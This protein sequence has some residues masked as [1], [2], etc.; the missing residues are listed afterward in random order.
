MALARCAFPAAFEDS[1]SLQTAKQGEKLHL[2]GL[3]TSPEDGVRVLLDEF[4]LFDVEVKNSKQTPGEAELVIAEGAVDVRHGVAVLK[5][6]K[7]T[8]W[9]PGV[10][11]RENHEPDVQSGHLHDRMCSQV[12]CRS[13]LNQDGN[14]RRVP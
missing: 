9:H 6:A 2:A 11:K 4:G 14:C 1:L 10:H 3:V 12:I 13:L 8:G 7:V 5:G